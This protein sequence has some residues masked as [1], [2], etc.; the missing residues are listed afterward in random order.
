MLELTGHPLYQTPGLAVS[1]ELTIETNESAAEYTIGFDGGI[2][3]GS[4]LPTLG[5]EGS[6]VR[7]E[8]SP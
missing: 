2:Q 7:G 1:I 8:V 4:G 3:L 6:Y 5:V